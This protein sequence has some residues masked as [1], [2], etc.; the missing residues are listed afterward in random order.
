M[1]ISQLVVTT[2]IVHSDCPRLHLDEVLLFP[3]PFT[4]PSLTH[5]NLTNVLTSVSTGNLPYCLEIPD[6]VKRKITDQY[7]DDE[8]QRQQFINYYI[9]LSPYGTSMSWAEVAGALHYWEETT[10]EASAKK[11]VHGAPGVGVACVA[12]CCNVEYCTNDVMCP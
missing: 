5:S 7:K 6:S 11:F 1:D 12:M 3:L 2:L 9:R 8:Q 4:D 10:A